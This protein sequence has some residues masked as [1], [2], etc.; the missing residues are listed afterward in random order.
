[1]DIR[2]RAVTFDAADPQSL[3]RFWSD[4]TGREIITSGPDLARVKSEIPGGPA[5][6]F[7]RVPESKTVKD[8]IH[9]DLETGD[10]A[11]EV[12]RITALGAIFHSEVKG[13][14]HEWTVLQDPEG[15]EFC[16]IQAVETDSR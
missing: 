3:A 11:A 12:T 14:T 6:L 10:R 8:R 16:I 2:L 5:L 15:N 7:L 1:M 9:L 13:T 4:V